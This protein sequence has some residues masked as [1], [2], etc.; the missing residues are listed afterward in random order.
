M[1]FHEEECWRI[2]P[3]VIINFFFEVIINLDNRTN[4]ILKILMKFFW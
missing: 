1:E 3:G 4:Y 2:G